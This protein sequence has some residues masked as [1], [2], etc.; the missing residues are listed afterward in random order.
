MDNRARKVAELQQFFQSYIDKEKLPGVTVAVRQGGELVWEQ[1]FGVRDDRGTPMTSETIFGVASM[2]KGLTCA[3]LAALEAEGKASFMDAACKYVPGLRVKGMPPETLLLHHLATHSS[4]VPPL[5]LLA[6]SLAFHSPDPA[7]APEEVEKLEKRRREAT[8]KVASVQDIVEYFRDGDYQPMGHPGMYNSYSN[9]SFALL[10]AAVDRIAGQPLEL[11]MR[12]KVFK[13]LGMTR[14]ALDLDASEAAGLGELTELFNKK[15]NGF[16][17][18]TAWDVAPPYRGCGWVKSTAGDM[19]RFYEALCY[20]GVVGGKVVLPGAGTL[21]GARFAELPHDTAYCYGLM[22]HPFR[23]GGKEFYVVE[24]AGG[25]HGVATKGGFVKGSDGISAAVLCN[26]EEAAVSPLL[27]AVFAVMLGFEAGTSSY[28]WPEPDGEPA[29]PEGYVGRF[30]Q[31]ERFADDVVVE[32]RDGK[33]VSVGKD[34][35]KRLAFRG[36]A[37]FVAEDAELAQARWDQY[38][39]FFDEHGQAKRLR[40]GSRMYT[41]VEQ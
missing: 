16:S 6:W 15:G 34:E 20:E 7:D 3:T 17:S 37:K 33:L 19:A 40:V 25:L 8:S 38:Q 30:H 35:V 2:S 26:W 28:F 21:Y 41:C 23:A 27:A 1:A 12:E 36:T 14:S 24:H 5:P 29:E 11:V 4:G 18:D 10:S 9:D 39:F 31:D 13:P 32:L 22:K